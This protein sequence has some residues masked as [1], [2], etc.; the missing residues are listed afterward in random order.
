M[1]V[2]CVTGNIHIRNSYTFSQHT[3]IHCNRVCYWLLSRGEEGRR[4]GVGEGEGVQLIYV[5]NDY[6]YLP[7]RE[8]C[9]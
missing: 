6:R 9:F 2:S 1:K 5:T 3:T 8:D 7:G 4:G